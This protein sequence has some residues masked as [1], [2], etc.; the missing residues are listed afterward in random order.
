MIFKG[1]T[2]FHAVIAKIVFSLY[3][4]PREIVLYPIALF[5]HSAD[6]RRVS[7]DY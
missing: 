5:S 6:I 7:H 4:M 2:L 3:F 1:I